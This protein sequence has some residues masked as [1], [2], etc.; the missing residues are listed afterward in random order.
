MSATVADEDSLDVLFQA[1]TQATS[2]K[3]LHLRVFV[4][5]QYQNNSEIS[6]VSIRDDNAFWERLQQFVS[7]RGNELKF[8]W[9][10][11]VLAKETSNTQTELCSILGRTFGPSHENAPR[12]RE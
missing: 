10:L 5:L 12:R 6:D 8:S 3:V 9:N 11:D 7:E 4:P 2:L 1:L